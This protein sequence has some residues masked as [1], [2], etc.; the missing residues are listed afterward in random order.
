MSC[1]N[2]AV[3]LCSVSRGKQRERSED[4]KI[5]T[6]EEKLKEL[7]WLS[8]EK[9]AVDET[10]ARTFRHIRGNYKGKI[11]FSVYTEIR[12]AI[13]NNFQLSRSW[14]VRGKL[15]C[16]LRSLCIFIFY[17]YFLEEGRSLF[18]GVVGLNKYIY[19]FIFFFMVL[20]ITPVRKLGSMQH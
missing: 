4:L 5:H 12:W 9:R 3:P 7:Q 18:L 19:I 16:H 15:N 13:K 10:R 1:P 2:E 8:L 14:S 20:G 17:F 6:K 11:L